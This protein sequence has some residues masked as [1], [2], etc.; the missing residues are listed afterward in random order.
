MS[1]LHSLNSLV[2]LS[3][4]LFLFDIS[5][6]F[7]C[8][9]NNNSSYSINCIDSIYIVLGETIAYLD[10]HTSFTII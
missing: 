8:S 3:L 10:I 5:F 9:N 7:P 2:M 4:C 1:P 6:V